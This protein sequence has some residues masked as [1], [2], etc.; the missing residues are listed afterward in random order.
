MR[1]GSG[2]ARDGR[3]RPRCFKGSAF[4]T[5]FLVTDDFIS[6]NYHKTRSR[7]KPLRFEQIHSVS[8]MGKIMVGNIIR[9]P[10]FSPVRRPTVPYLV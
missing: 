7:S 3:K 10:P 9:N 4:A 8:N 1:S 6:Q 5:G 2:L